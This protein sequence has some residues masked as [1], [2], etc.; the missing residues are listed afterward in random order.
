M[1]RPLRIAEPTRTL[2]IY[3]HLLRESSYLPVFARAFFDSRI[4]ERFRHNG[5]D[6][7]NVD[8]YKKKARHGLRYLRAVNNGDLPRM[9]R[10]ILLAFGRTGRRRRDLM[11][12]LLH[13]DAPKDSDALEAYTHEIENLIAGGRERDFLDSWD[14]EK[15]RTFAKSQASANLRDSPKA[16]IALK[17]IMIEKHL[18]KENIWG[19]PPAK[20]LLRSKERKAW[21][22]LADKVLPPLP[23]SEWETLRDLAL[24]RVK[25][26]AIQAPRRRPVAK[27][28]YS[29]WK[30]PNPWNWHLYATQP[31][32]AA[33]RQASR[34]F[35]LLSGRVDDNTPTGDP[36]A[37]GSRRITPRTWQHLLFQIWTLTAKMEKNPSGK[38]WDITWGGK[39][40]KPPM[41]RADSELF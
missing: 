10:V 33:D 3:R 8:T 26:P 37:I 31:V 14:K 29:R 12:D 21:K 16:D 1:S 11:D 7:K 20:K 28:L 15:L 19:M 5:N 9:R 30:P 39:T 17:Q 34:R 23:T 4:K 40:F 25:D 41:A 24:G 13:G 36:H 6:W 2:H 35:K 22:V 32:V 38:G 18:P 27:N